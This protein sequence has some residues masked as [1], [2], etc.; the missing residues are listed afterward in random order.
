MCHALVEKGRND[1]VL[2]HTPVDPVSSVFIASKARTQFDLSL[3]L[4]GWFW[5]M[6]IHLLANLAWRKPIS[7][8][9]K[10]NCDLA[11]I[12]NCSDAT[13]A[14]AAKGR[15]ALDWLSL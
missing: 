11:V 14:E 4:I 5:I 10:F 7:G 2:N 8:S 3:P 1:S 15:L 12:P 13:A 6:M 9:L